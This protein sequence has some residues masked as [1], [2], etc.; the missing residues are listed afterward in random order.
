MPV[1]LV[2]GVF[3]VAVAISQQ[4]E[5]SRGLGGFVSKKQR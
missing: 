5:S 2:G 4:T 3:V 1:E